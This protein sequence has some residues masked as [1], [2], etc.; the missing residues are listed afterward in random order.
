MST[1]TIK[2]FIAASIL[3]TFAGS[4]WAQE[5]SK[6]PLNKTAQTSYTL[7][8]LGLVGPS[9]GPLVITNDGLIAESVPV[10]DAWHAAISFLGRTLIDLAKAGG[11]GG[12]NSAAFG[13]NEFAQSAGEAETADSNSE[14]FC[15]YGTQ[16]VCA[17]FIWQNGFMRALPL[18]KDENGVAGGNAAAKGINIWGQVAG[19]AENTTLDS[20]CPPYDP[21]SFQYQTYQAKPVIWA[22]GKI[23]ELHTSGTDSN[24]NAFRDPD[25]VAFRINNSGEAVGTTGTCAGFTGFSYVSGLHATLW[26]ADGSVID[27]GNLGG[28]ATPPSG[29]GLGNFGNLAYYVNSRGDVVG[30]SGTSDGSAHAFLWT[31]EKLIQDVGTVPANGSTPADAA[32]IGLAIS[33]LDDIGGVS[34]PANANAL[35]R[36]FLRPH[37]GTPVDLNSL[38]TENTADLYLFTVCSINSRGEIIGLAL[39]TEGNFH[40]YLAT[41]NDSAADS[42][43]EASA[44]SRS[45][46]FEYA[47]KV[48]RDRL[49]P[50]R[51]G[52]R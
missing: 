34:F 4:N 8:D 16:H 13:V 26:K 45:S 14:D 25:G 32:S 35:P 36:A 6:L 28:I 10:S 23:R 18:L 21:A 47:W 1:R 20:T 30:T 3:T 38:V 33:D 40:G 11:L 48:L 2:I 42:S 49:G 51:A 24:G 46:R 37:G 39:D 7:T 41:P 29:S 44:E 43:T 27:L 19:S 12:P 15:A 52:P 5:E 17:A 22:N 9:P 50:F 31:P